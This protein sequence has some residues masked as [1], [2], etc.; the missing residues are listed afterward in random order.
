MSVNTEL[1]PNEG[2]VIRV[3]TS[4]KKKKKSFHFISPSVYK[5]IEN[6]EEIIADNAKG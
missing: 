5:V 2:A 4:K 1:Y 6:E 3:R